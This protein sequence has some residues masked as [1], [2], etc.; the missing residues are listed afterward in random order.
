MSKTIDSLWKFGD[1][2]MSA[3]CDYFG[4]ENMMD[5][6]KYTIILGLYKG[7][8]LLGIPKETVE[9]A[10]LSNSLDQLIH[11]SYKE[12]SSDYYK[13]FCQKNMSIGKTCLI[14]DE[15]VEEVYDD[16]TDKL[17]EEACQK[18]G[19]DWVDRQR[20]IQ[21]S[22]I[23]KIMEK[24]HAINSNPKPQFYDCIYDEYGQ[25]MANDFL[26]GKEVKPITAKDVKY[27][28]KKALSK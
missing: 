17:L 21:L 23:D 14:E 20:D 5:Q 3:L 24:A 10:F 27:W 7:L 16:T 28:V 12:K 18:Y 22:N 11:N 9:Q 2:S 1:I 26:S 25:S 13:M 19:K 4:Y 8:F 15:L 6:E